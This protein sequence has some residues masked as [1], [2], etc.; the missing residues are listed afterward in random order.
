MRS[1]NDNN[2]AM[3]KIP[4]SWSYEINYDGGFLWWNQQNNS[5]REVIQHAFINE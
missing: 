5:R 3:I 1:N 2:T 4:V